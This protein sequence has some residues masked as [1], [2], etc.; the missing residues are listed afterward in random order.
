MVRLAETISGLKTALGA[1]WKK[2]AIVACGE[3]GRTA[4]MNGSGGTDHGSG[5]LAL[6]A[7]GAVAGGKVLGEWPGLGEGNLYEDRDLKPTEDIRRY[8]AWL[9]AGLYCVPQ[10]KFTSEI[11]PGVDMGQKLTLV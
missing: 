8:I 7:G 6:L 4:R 11:F 1:N 10:D 9:A 3:F 2:T 5:G